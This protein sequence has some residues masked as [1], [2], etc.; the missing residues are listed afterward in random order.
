VPIDLNGD[1]DRIWSL[2]RHRRNFPSF[3]TSTTGLSSKHVPNGIRLRRER[4]YAGRDWTIDARI[5]A[6]TRI[7][8]VT[9]ATSH[10]MSALYVSS[11]P[12]RA[13]RTWRSWRALGAARGARTMTFV[14]LF[15]RLRTW[16]D[17][18]TV[19]TPCSYVNGHIEDR[20]TRSSVEPALPQPI[21]LFW[22][23]GGRTVSLSFVEVVRRA[24]RS[25]LAKAI[26]AWSRYADLRWRLGDAH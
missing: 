26:V 13:S 18:S 1:A 21:K 12:K 22:N 20:S 4:H 24:P 8:A 11:G 6:T 15:F 9:S 7:L 23:C 16:M 17:G 14:V 5:T 2:P 10:E 3:L 19:F 25:A